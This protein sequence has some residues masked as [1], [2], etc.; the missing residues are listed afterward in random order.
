MPTKTDRSQ[1]GKVDKVVS[2]LCRGAL[3][4][5]LDSKDWEHIRVAIRIVFET[6]DFLCKLHPK[7]GV[8]CDLATF[9]WVESVELLIEF[10]AWTRQIAHVIH[11][12]RFSTRPLSGDLWSLRRK[13]RRLAAR[14]L[15]RGTHESQRWRMLVTLGAIE[16][17]IAGLLWDFE[18]RPKSG[19]P[20]GLSPEPH[21]SGNPHGGSRSIERRRARRTP[22]PVSLGGKTRTASRTKQRTKQDGPA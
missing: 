13:H 6:D 11:G 12:V 4:E 19:D 5:Q 22:P 1:S 9:N 16:I 20:V 14:L 17:T 18:W 10:L 7:G 21:L 3:R 2:L 15:E 8:A